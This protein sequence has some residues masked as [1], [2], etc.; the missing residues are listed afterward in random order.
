M[1]FSPNPVSLSRQVWNYARL[2]PVT[3]LDDG[4]VAACK[5]PRGDAVFRKLAQAGVRLV[6]NLHP[7][8][9]APEHL[10]RF[11][12]SELHLPV[13]DFTAPTQEQLKAGVVAMRER[14]DSGEPVAVHCGGG[15][16][17]TGTLVACYLVSRGQPPDEAIARV[18]AARP[19]SV[20]T[21][22]QELA[23]KLFATSAAEP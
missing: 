13:E 19:G 15:L 17:R 6:V 20:E 16:G 22:E 4:R 18:R 11:G 10:E 3:W 9:H 23:V 21:A 12:L 7:R 14:T 8:A 5:Y 1:R 2:Q